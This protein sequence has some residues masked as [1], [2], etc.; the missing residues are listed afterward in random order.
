MNISIKS[1]L[2]LYLRNMRFTSSKCACTLHFVPR[3]QEAHALDT[4]TNIARN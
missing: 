4:F 2:I 3:L 1:Y